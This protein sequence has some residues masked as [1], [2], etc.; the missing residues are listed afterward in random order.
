[1][2]TLRLRGIEK[3]L[4]RRV[5]FKSDSS[6]ATCATG[7]KIINKYVDW[8]DEHCRSEIRKLPKR[9]VAQLK[10][11]SSDATYSEEAKWE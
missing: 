10:S 7:V 8:S 2:R 9:I 11:T 1:M 6:G 3:Q 4:E 5:Q